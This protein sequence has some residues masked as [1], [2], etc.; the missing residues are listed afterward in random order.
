MTDVQY[1]TGVASFFVLYILLEVPSQYFLKKIGPKYYLSGLL[2][3]CG[4]VMASGAAIQS[5]IGF[6]MMRLALGATESGLMPGFNA[7]IAKYYTRDELSVRIAIFF[8]SASISGA[9][10]G[11]LAFGL[12]KLGGVAGLESWRWIWLLEGSF[13]AFVGV[14]AP[15]VFVDTPENAGSWLT[16]EEKRYLVLRQRYG[17][18]SGG[19]AR[20][21][22]FTMNLLVDL[23]KNWQT[24]PMI[25]IYISHS[26]LGYAISFSLPPLMKTLGYSN[27]KAY[28]IPVPIFLAACVLT[29][30]NSWWSDRRESRFLHI[31]GPFSLAIVGVALTIPTAGQKDLVGLSILGLICLTF[32]AYLAVPI[33][34][35][36][37]AANT[38]EPHRSV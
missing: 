34:I 35:S 21:E 12:A 23:A 38:V 36:W 18:G 2:F 5:P 1:N 33:S 4:V 28:L 9:F 13:T 14:I 29:I 27:E 3:G 22:A 19:V 24:Y 11:L 37:M 10:S 17:A 7:S 26:V 16:H 20:S 15:F 25:L 32:A 6:I 31:A 8:A 30:L